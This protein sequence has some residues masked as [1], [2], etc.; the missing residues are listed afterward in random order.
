MKKQLIGFFTAVS[1]MTVPAAAVNAADKANA[2]PDVYVNDSLIMFQDQNAKIIDGV[3]LVPARGVFESLGYDVEWDSDARTVKV[4]SDTGVRVV[5]LTIDS[6]IMQINTY[7]TIMEIEKTEYTLEVPAQIMNDRT[8]IPLRAISEAFDCGVEWDQDAYRVDI[9]SGEPILLEGAQPTPKPAESE[10]LTMSLST[11]AETISAGEEFDV[12]VDVSNTPANSFLSGITVTFN[13][14]KSKFEFVSGTLLNN[15]NEPLEATV[16]AEN[17]DYMTGTKALYVTIYGDTA[18]TTDGH[19]LKATFRS[20]N[21]ES[22][23]IAFGNNYDTLRGFESY[24]M[25]NNDNQDIIYDGQ[26]I[27]V[28]RTPLKIG[29]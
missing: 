6:D 4:T 26:N 23:E 24:L 2:E 13:Y 5:T 29:Q 7:K 17:P 1:L 14:D 8:M 22:G 9:T 15:N 11:D 27:I 3:T 21:G 20:V 16:Y 12:Y 10:M 18:R 19:V 28:D 25:Y